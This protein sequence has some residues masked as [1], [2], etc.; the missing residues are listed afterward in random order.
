[1]HHVRTDQ[2]TFRD[3]TNIRWRAS[4]FNF[5]DNDRSA[6]PYVENLWWRRRIMFETGEV[7]QVRGVHPVLC[8]AGHGV[9]VQLPVPPRHVRWN[10]H[11]QDAVH[12]IKLISWNCF[13]RVSYMRGRFN[14]SWSIGVE[15]LQRPRSLSN[16][17]EITNS[18][19][20]EALPCILYVPWL[21]YG[22]MVLSVTSHDLP[23][24]TSYT[25]IE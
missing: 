16:Y 22:Y 24:T 10:V 4:S 9:V 5:G 8:C 18:D 17:M 14:C 12:Q 25:M 15:R 2:I 21:G 3:L 6:E 13:L 7:P 20:H 23:L 19:S 1:M 11:S